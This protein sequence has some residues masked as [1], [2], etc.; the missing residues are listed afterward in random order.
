METQKPDWTRLNFNTL[1]TDEKSKF[2]VNLADE[3]AGNICPMAGEFACEI[4]TVRLKPEAVRVWGEQAYAQ[5]DS[6]SRLGT[7]YDQFLG[8][9]ELP[10]IFGCGALLT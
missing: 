8:F 4:V 10:R 5:P 7:I 1:L 3:L 2:I 6:A 9:V